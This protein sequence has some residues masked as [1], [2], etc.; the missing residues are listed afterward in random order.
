[1]CARYSIRICTITPAKV[2]TAQLK[3][4]RL[5]QINLYQLK[6]L[7]KPYFGIYEQPQTVC[8]RDIVIAPTYYEA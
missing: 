4:H 8:V 3:I 1:M 2:K 5:V 6:R 7:L